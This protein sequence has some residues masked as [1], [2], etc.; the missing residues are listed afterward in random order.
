MP[1]P[2]FMGCE[3]RRDRKESPLIAGNIALKKCDDMA[4]RGHMIA[5]LVSRFRSV[6]GT[7]QVW[8]RIVSKKST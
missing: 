5:V 3:L 6:I 8:R 1:L 4:R 2:S 7:V